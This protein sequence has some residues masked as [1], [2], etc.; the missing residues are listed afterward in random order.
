MNDHGP[1]FSQKSYS[2]SVVENLPVEPAAPIVQVTAHDNDE[3]INALIRYVI[4]E[5][6]EEGKLSCISLITEEHVALSVK[7]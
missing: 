6:N 1:A 5:G 7:V 2:A 3:G 4:T